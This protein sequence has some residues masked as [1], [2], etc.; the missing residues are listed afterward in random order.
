M[1]FPSVPHIVLDRFWYIYLQT[2]VFTTTFPEPLLFTACCNIVTI[3]LLKERV[4][5][6]EHQCNQR[7]VTDEK[8]KTYAHAREIGDLDIEMLGPRRL[9]FYKAT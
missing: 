4:A 5:Q 6:A 8:S 9:F 2:P 1:F 3:I 7:S